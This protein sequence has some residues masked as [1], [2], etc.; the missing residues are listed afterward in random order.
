MNHTNDAI[1]TPLRIA[2]AKRIGRPGSVER[3]AK[4]VCAASTEAWSVFECCQQQ[5]VM[6]LLLKD[7]ESNKLNG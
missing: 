1:V 3:L 5:R 4:F 2:K 6:G 7:Q